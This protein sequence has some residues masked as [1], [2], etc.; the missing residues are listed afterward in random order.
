MLSDLE[1]HSRTGSPV[2]GILSFP[3][4]LEF[5]AEGAWRYDALVLLDPVQRRAA[6]FAARAAS[7][8]VCDIPWAFCAFAPARNDSL[9]LDR[10]GPADRAEIHSAAGRYRAARAD[11]IPGA[12]RSG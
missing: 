4:L 7:A 6:P 3:R 5:P 9:G 11:R 12:S 1:P 8:G 10:R 2:T